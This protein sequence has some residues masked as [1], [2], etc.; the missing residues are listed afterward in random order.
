MFLICLF[1]TVSDF[2]D[3]NH[4]RTPDIPEVLATC[5]DT[6]KSNKNPIIIYKDYDFHY[7]NIEYDKSNQ[8]ETREELNELYI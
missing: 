8:S 6:I 1:T 2:I 7:L 3:I 5:F 4:L